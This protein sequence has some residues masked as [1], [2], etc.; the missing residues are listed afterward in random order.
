MPESFRPELRVSWYSRGE[1][2]D[3]ERRTEL[4]NV[5]ESELE[6]RAQRAKCAIERAEAEL[7]IQITADGLTTK[8]AR[9]FLEALPTVD[10]LMPNL[11]LSDLEKRRPLLDVRPR[12]GRLIELFLQ[13]SIALSPPKTCGT[14]AATAEATAEAGPVKTNGTRRDHAPTRSLGDG[15]VRNQSRMRRVPKR[16]PRRRSRPHRAG[17]FHAPGISKNLSGRQ[18]FRR[19]NNEHRCHKVT[20]RHEE[21]QAKLLADADARDKENKRDEMRLA[22]IKIARERPDHLDKLATA[23]TGA[24]SADRKLADEQADLERKI[25][26]RRAPSR[27]TP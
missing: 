12:F 24:I 26:A 19:N 22:E 23:D 5:A 21:N 11:Q 17:R 3:K 7:L 25:Y 9:A 6:A 14:A 18:M 16:F 8:A 1:N 13:N 20:H 15:R 10:Q 4:R 27:A 2:A